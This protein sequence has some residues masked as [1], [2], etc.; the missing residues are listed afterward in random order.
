MKVSL[1]KRECQQVLNISSDYNITLSSEWDDGVYECAMMGGDYILAKKMTSRNLNSKDLQQRK[2]WLYR[3]IKADFATGS[4]SEVIGA[5]RELITLIEDD[6]ESEY[7]D[8]YRILFDTYQRLENSE[9][10]LSAIVKIQSIFGSDYK[11]IERYIAVMSM[12]SDKK[13]DNIVIKYGEEVVKIQNS[14]SSYAQS[15]FVEFS[16]YQSYIN[17]EELNKALSI[18]KSLDNIELDKRTRARQK[19][20]LGTVLS[21]LWRD[22]ESQVAYQESIDADPKSPWAALA[23]SA[24]EI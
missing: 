19:Y 7:K 10:L 8:V 23:K 17:T 9:K 11:D 1:E 15:P 5:S 2:K 21:K 6:K 20:L 22:E 18:I 16:L 13:D 14:S 3:H 12:G 4:Y 24:Q